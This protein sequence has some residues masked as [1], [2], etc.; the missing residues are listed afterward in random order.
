MS[1]K[2]GMLGFILLFVGCDAVQKAD[3]VVLDNDTHKPISHVH[4]ARF[5]PDDYKDTDNSVAYSDSAGIFHFYAIS[6]TGNFDLY[7]SKEGYISRKIEYRNGPRP[8]TIYLG[9]DSK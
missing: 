3:G 9:K 6:M 2:L 7:F 1:Y 5:A 8:D 4:M